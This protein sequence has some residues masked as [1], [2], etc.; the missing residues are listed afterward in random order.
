MGNRDHELVPSG[1]ELASRQ[2]ENETPTPTENSIGPN[3][4]STCGAAS[5]ATRVLGY[6]PTECHV[7]PIR[8]FARPV[9]VLGL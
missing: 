3:V 9:P 6:P 5:S 7:Q 1:N 4:M 2:H 8:D